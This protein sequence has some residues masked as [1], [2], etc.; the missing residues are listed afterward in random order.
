M[1][2]SGGRRQAEKSGFNWANVPFKEIGII[3]LIIVVIAVVAVFAVHMINKRKTEDTNSQGT[4][5]GDSVDEDT[6]PTEYEGY[7]VLGQIVIDKINLEQYIL[8]STENDAMEKAPVK[9]Y[10]NDI[11]TTGNFCIAGH[12]Y[13]EIF[14]DLDKLEVGDEFYIIDTEETIQDYKVTEIVEVEPTDLSVLMPVDDKIQVTLITCIDGATKRLV[15]KAERI[16]IE[17]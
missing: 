2:M 11:N 4:V 7:K 12:N 17:G 8:D 10:G 6:M 13:E 3:A 14:K 15:V 1:N 5:Q 9:L 16:D